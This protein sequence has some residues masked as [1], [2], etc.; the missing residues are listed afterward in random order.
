MT[1]GNV[2]AGG[3]IY[4]SKINE[5]VNGLNP[6]VSVATAAV[7]TVAAGF[8]VNDVRAATLA[9]GTLVQIDLYLSNVAAITAATGNF[10]DVTCFTMAPAYVPLHFTTFVFGNGSTT[11]EG[12]IMSGTGAV[13]LR[14]A[15]DTIAAG[16]NIRISATYIVA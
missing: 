11:G 9:G 10:A 3:V 2:A 12:Q 8:T 6:V 16:S 7:G 1:I 15:S 14:S 4:A 5:L 13:S